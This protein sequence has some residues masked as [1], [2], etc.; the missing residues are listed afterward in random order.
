MRRRGELSE[1]ELTVVKG[2]IT[3]EE[4]FEKF[5]K[6]CHMRN[7]R[8]ATIQYYKDALH[9]ANKIVNKQFVEWERSDIETLI[10]KSKQ[11]MKVTTINTRLRALRSF[12]NFL[13]RNNLKQENPMKNVKLLRDRQKA[14]ETLENFEIETLVKCIRKNK[15]FVS[16]RDEVIF[17]VFLDT[18]VSV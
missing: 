18:G 16:I 13:E 8:P 3:D 7:L 5:Y 9:A 6:D 14:I 4:A 12:Y 11:L 2:K 10:T 15:T 17:L 1:A